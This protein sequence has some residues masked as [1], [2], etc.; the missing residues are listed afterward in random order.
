[1]LR[2]LITLVV[3]AIFACLLFALYK[4]KRLNDQVSNFVHIETLRPTYVK[5]LFEEPSKGANVLVILFRPDCE[6]CTD[7]VNQ[8]VRKYSAFE[9]HRLYFFTEVSRQET[10]RFIQERGLAPLPNVAVGILSH[11]AFY[12]AFGPTSV[13]HLFIYG[14]DG[15]LRHEFRGETKIETILEA[16]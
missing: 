1:M 6:Y 11:D 8:I 16:L 9:K 7:E 12:K 2:K 15:Q 10:V 5:G 13:P 4:K 14:P 3:L